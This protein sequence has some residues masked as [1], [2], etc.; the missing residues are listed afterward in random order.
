MTR[1]TRAISAAFKQPYGIDPTYL[2]MNGMN[3]GKVIT[4]IDTESKAGKVS[5][6]ANLGGAS[7]SSIPSG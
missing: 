1:G 3:A 2:G 6:D 5:I 7:R 4:R